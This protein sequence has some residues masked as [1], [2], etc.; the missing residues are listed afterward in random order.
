MSNFKGKTVVVTGGTGSFG[1]T[2]VKHLLSSDVREVR[3]FSRDELKQDNLRRE[4][5][6]SRVSFILGD[7]RDPESM[8]HLFSRADLVFHAAALKQVPSGDFFPLE[9]TKTNVIGSANV[10][11]AAEDSG[12]SSLVVLSTDKAVYPIN[13]M[14]ISKAL[15]EK[16]AISEA[17]RIGQNGMKINVTRYGNVM[18][19]RGSVIPN[20]IKQARLRGEV[21]VTDKKMTRFMMSLEE[22]VDLVEFALFSNS[23][24]SIF[25]R[26]AP[27]A[28]IEVLVEAIS[29]ILGKTIKSTNIGVRHGEKLHETLISAEETRNLVATED[30]LEVPLDSRN[31]DYEKFFDIGST[32]KSIGEA[33]TSENARALEAHELASLITK[34]RAHQEENY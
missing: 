33:F 20:F 17:R 19:S 27:A 31:L 5:G 14:G 25:V 24:G 6:D 29:I 10:I 9:V 26:T 16:V 4:L 3:V 7:T 12:V 22:S 21:T 2:M 30:F 15:M 34:L 1:S 28:S 8:R 18:M 13:A 11:R 32:P 23:Q